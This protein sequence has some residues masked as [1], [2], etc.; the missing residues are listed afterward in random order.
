MAI[1]ERDLLLIRRT[2][3]LARLAR[4][5]G[6]HPFGALLAFDDTI[7]LEAGNTVGTGHNPTHHA[8]LNLVQRAFAELRPEVICRT[9]LYTSTEPCPMCTGAI[10]WAGIRKLVFSVAATRLG[11][12][13]GDTFCRSSRLLFDNA[14]EQTVVIG[15]VL[16]EEG[17]EVHQG[18]WT[19]TTSRP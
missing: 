17:L 12:L 18:F 14:H 4:S 1:P 7:I 15:P 16:E 3:E 9:T 2:I 6:N 11:S 10:F 8:E 5:R 19:N 13:T